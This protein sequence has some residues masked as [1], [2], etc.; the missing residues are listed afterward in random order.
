MFQLSLS[1]SPQL[2][3][4][5][6]FPAREEAERAQTAAVGQFS[7]TNW[8]QQRGKWAVT[9][10]RHTWVFLLNIFKSM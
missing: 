7:Q 2:S 8:P 10:Q 6:S 9:K 3:P 5:V 4:P 1:T